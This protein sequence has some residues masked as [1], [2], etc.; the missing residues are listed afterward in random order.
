MGCHKNKIVD[1]AESEIDN[2]RNKIL[3]KLMGSNK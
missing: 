1:I 3:I 2:E